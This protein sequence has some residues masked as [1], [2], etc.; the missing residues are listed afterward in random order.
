MPERK[1]LSAK[2][3]PHNLKE[4]KT[5]T[6]SGR[7]FTCGR[8]GRSEGKKPHVSDALAHKWVLG[9]PPGTDIIISL[10][11]HKSKDPK[12]PKGKSEFS[13]YSFYGEWDDSAERRDR[14]SFQEWL[15]Q[16]QKERSLKVIEHPTYDKLPIEPTE[17]I[18]T[19]STEISRL[20]TLG[21]TV[22]LMDSGGMERTGSVCGHMIKEGLLPEQ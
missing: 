7:L 3:E 17:V 5:G 13:F 6:S 1:P 15:D 11:G 22:V 16:W 12:H 4:W 2:K 8:P 19:V 18:D 14:L 21:H 10:L 20:L 9:L